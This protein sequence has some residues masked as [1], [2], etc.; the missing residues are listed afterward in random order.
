VVEVKHN[1]ERSRYELW[2]D[3]RLAGIAEYDAAGSTVVFFHTEVA[4]LLRG[5]GLGEEL[6]R[7][8]LDDVRTRGDTVIPRCWFVAQ[9][10]RQNPGYAD[11]LAA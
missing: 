1:A 4:P 6:I 2:I 3:E 9:F 8:A 7:G 11:L 5:R 10:I